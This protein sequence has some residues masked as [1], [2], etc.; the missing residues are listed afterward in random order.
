MDGKTFFDAFVNDEQFF[1]DEFTS[2]V[3]TVDGNL[4][5]STGPLVIST[6]SFA[7]LLNSILNGD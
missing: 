3:K 1:L 2:Q 5:G 4:E 6:F 7:F